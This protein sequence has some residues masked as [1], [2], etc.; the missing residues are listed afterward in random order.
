MFRFGKRS[1]KEIET[2]WPRGQEIL[3]KAMSY[4]VMDF[5]LPRYSGGRTKEDQKFLYSLGRT[6]P[7]NKVTWT[8]NSNHLIRPELGYGFAFDVVPYVH[9]EYVWEEELCTMLATV[10]FK[11]ALELNEPIDWGY[12]L[13]RK[14]YPHF[15]K[16]R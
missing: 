12:H 1:L 15:Q 8:L 13:W 10:I 9:G 2:V 3:H 16:R 11:A 5:G 4:Q 7:G 6:R 14:D